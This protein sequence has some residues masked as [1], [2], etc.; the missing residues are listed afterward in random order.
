MHSGRSR[1]RPGSRA[2]VGEDS[3]KGAIRRMPHDDDFLQLNDEEVWDWITWETR[4]NP[5][6]DYRR[7]DEAHFLGLWRADVQLLR[8]G[9][10]L[11]AEREG[12]Y[13]HGK[14][15]KVFTL[16]HFDYADHGGLIKTFLPCLSINAGKLALPPAL[17]ATAYVIFPYNYD[18]N[19][20][21]SRAIGT[22]LRAP[23]MQRDRG[24]R[25]LQAELLRWATASRSGIVAVPDAGV[26]AAAVHAYADAEEP[27]WPFRAT[28][29][30]DDSDATKAAAW[31]RNIWGRDPGNLRDFTFLK[32]YARQDQ[33]NGFELYSIKTG[34]QFVGLKDQTSTSKDLLEENS[35]HAMLRSD[36]ISR[37][38]QAYPHYTFETKYQLEILCVQMYLG[39][40][41]LD[42]K[43]AADRWDGFQVRHLGSM[44]DDIWF[45][46]LAIPT[47]GKT[48]AKRWAHATD[49]SWKQF[50]SKNFAHKL[51]RSKAEMLAMF[52]LQ[53]MTANA[54]NMLVAFKRKRTNYNDGTEARHI[55]LRD[56][57]DTLLNDHFYAVLK[58]KVGG[59]FKALW[60]HE[61][62]DKFGVTLKSAIG[63]YFKPIITRLGTSIVFF[64]DP[65]MQGD[66]AKNDQQAQM[67]LVEWGLT[68]NLGFIEYFT[69]NLGYAPDWQEGAA[70]A[71][72]DIGALLQRLLKFSGYNKA[73]AAS[74]EQLTDDILKLHSKWRW[75]LIELLEKTAIEDHASIRFAMDNQGMRLVDAHDLLVGADVQQFICSETGKDALLA[76]H[77][78]AM[79]GA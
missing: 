45:P 67:V 4:G 30:R 60:E 7:G 8:Q 17:P 74:Y 37:I 78:K 9:E 23:A 41:D 29:R 58:D 26:D 76:L 64:F 43:G 53:H 32:G 63:Q 27:A 31:V 14:W 54:Q 61:V 18:D 36:L 15:L 40:Q 33:Q 25:R 73:N 75:T 16:R 48:F 5:S 66:L 47:S 22:D 77:R 57:G 51:G 39:R 11:S 3:T 69:K 46:A 1:H 70:G 6:A 59:P 68:H 71:E 20:R 21:F 62:G 72:P 44:G 56:I 19:S 35:V 52:G 55:I 38:H 12:S 79:R 65:F 34:V 13:I 49:F 2:S 50:W 24:A 42:G 28:V 10:A